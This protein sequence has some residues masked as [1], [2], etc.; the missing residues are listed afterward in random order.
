MFKSL[1]SNDHRLVFAKT[2][3]KASKSNI[4]QSL[5]ADKSTL[6]KKY[7]T[8]RSYCEQTE[9]K[10]TLI[11]CDVLTDMTNKKV[12]ST[13]SNPIKSEAATSV[14]MKTSHSSFGSFESGASSVFVNPE[15]RTRSH[16]PGAEYPIIYL[17]VVHPLLYSQAQ[18][19]MALL[20]KTEY[21]CCF[22]ALI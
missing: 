16:E 7:Q 11:L 8:L 9:R 6:C 20:K 13:F 17:C 14:C 5:T 19:R 4:F 3:G 10:R 2:C 1:Y 18:I 15:P 21:L 12:F 22:F